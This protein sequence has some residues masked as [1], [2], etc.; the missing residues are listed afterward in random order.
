MPLK[1]PAPSTP[2]KKPRDTGV[3][4]FTSSLPKGTY[5]TRHS[6]PKT[7]AELAP[8]F[9]GTPDFQLKPAHETPK[10]LKTKHDKAVL[11]QRD[12]ANDKIFAARE[13]LATKSAINSRVAAQ[14]G[15]LPVTKTPFGGGTDKKNPYETDA[16]TKTDLAKSRAAQLKQGGL[17]DPAQHLREAMAMLHTSQ[18]RSLTFSDKHQLPERLT[19][20]AVSLTAE[21]GKQ[22]LAAAFGNHQT[23]L[24]T[25]KTA[26]Q[27]AA[28]THL[29]D[30]GVG[31]FQSQ[32]PEGTY[33]A[34]HF[35]A[36]GLAKTFLSNAEKGT[37]AMAGFGGKT[38]VD[39]SHSVGVLGLGDPQALNQF[40]TELS[41][42]TDKIRGAPKPSG[43]PLPH[44]D[45]TN[46][47]TPEAKAA[48]NGQPVHLDDLATKKALYGDFA[49]G[50]R[51]RQELVYLAGQNG[52]DVKEAPTW[53][54]ALLADYAFH[55]QEKSVT[56]F[57]RNAAADLGSQAA[58]A[59]AP[60]MFGNA[61][62]QDIKDHSIR[63][64]AR[65]AGG[66]A[67][68]IIDVT[69]G[70]SSH[71]LQNNLYNKPFTTA[72]VLLPAG[73]AAGLK[74]GKTLDALGVDS[75]KG[76][77]EV[78][79]PTRAAAVDRGLAEPGS[80]TITVGASQHPI[81]R[82]AQ[83]LHDRILAKGEHPDE[84][85]KRQQGR[86]AATHPAREAVRQA[87]SVPSKIGHKLEGK[88]ERDRLNQKHMEARRQEGHE[89]FLAHQKLLE[90]YRNLPW[91]KDLVKKG[92]GGKEHTIEDI[93]YHEG[94]G[95]SP[96]QMADMYREHARRTEEDAGRLDKLA[97]EARTNEKAAR[98]SGDDASASDFA[99]QAG[100]YDKEIDDIRGKGGIIEKQ[101]AAAKRSDE[102][103][104]VMGSDHPDVQ[105][106]VDAMRGASKLS[107]DILQKQGLIDQKG[108]LWGDWQY[109]ISAIDATEGPGTKLGG[110]RGTEAW[111]LVQ[112]ILPAREEFMAARADFHG[113]NPDEAAGLA[114][115]KDIHSSEANHQLNRWNGLRALRREPG[116]P[117]ENAQ[118]M[119][120]LDRA[121]ATARHAQ[122][123]GRGWHTKQAWYR[124]MT[125]E[126]NGLRKDEQ[127]RASAKKTSIIRRRE[128]DLAAAK[129]TRQSPQ[130]IAEMQ[131]LLDK[132]K[133]EAD[134][135][136]VP[137]QRLRTLERSLERA[138]V[139][140]NTRNLPDEV[141]DAIV[142]SELRR[143][144]TGQVQTFARQYVRNALHDNSGL[145]DL[146]AR[147]AD[148]AEKFKAASGGKTV[149]QAER[150]HL[151]G[152]HYQR[153]L[154]ALRE[155][156]SHIDPF[157]MHM[158]KPNT[159]Y[160]LQPVRVASGKQW[161]EA[162]YTHDMHFLVAR[163]LEGLSRKQ[164]EAKMFQSLADEPYFIS[165]PPS[166][167][168][169]PPGFIALDREL[170][171]NLQKIAKDPEQV[172]ALQK[173]LEEARGT[174]H[175]GTRV[176]GDD[177][178]MV[179]RHLAEWLQA[180]LKRDDPNRQINGLLKATNMYRRWML[181]SLPRTYVNN[182]LGNPIIAMVMGAKMRHYVE[183]RDLLKNH[184]E[185]LDNTLRK[186]GTAANIMDGGKKMT[187]WQ[188]M[189]RSANSFQED[190]GNMMVYLM[191]AEKSFR[192]G[193]DLKIWNSIDKQSSEYVQFLSDAAQGKNPDAAAWSKKSAEAFGDMYRTMK[194]DNTL[195][196]LFLFHRWVGHM[197]TLTAYT[198]PLKYPGR[199]L[200]LQQTA[201]LADQY[202]KEH[203]V[204]PDW[205]Q[206]MIPLWSTMEKAGGLPQSVTWALS[207]GGI[208]PF[209]TPGQTFDLGT[210]D[211][212]KFPGQSIVAA[213]LNPGLRVL[214]EFATGHRFDTLE[215]FKDWHGR[216]IS[217]FDAH[218]LA[219]G[220]IANTPVLNT[221]FPRSGLSDD[222]IQIP[223]PL[224]PQHPRW[225][226]AASNDPS[227]A[228]PQ[229]MGRGL[230]WDWALRIGAA[231]GAP[232]RPI[233]AAGERTNLSA[234][235]T[236]TWQQQQ[237]D[238]REAQDEKEKELANIALFKNDRA[239]WNK[240]FGIKP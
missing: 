232:I 222:T 58:L 82:V 150:M 158:H 45:I 177:T 35:D 13:A 195:A 201:Q 210:P 22:I 60:G 215:P 229:A 160:G 10:Q 225:S 76:S 206:G 115:N 167:S 131:R 71:S 43:K 101:L 88:I 197:I 122:E 227:Y 99:E 120:A 62:V 61:I 161:E 23:P 125:D 14:A 188:Q 183:A 41:S 72:S 56:G 236:V 1:Q 68:G 202:R 111:D 178:V 239:A 21:E 142:N 78:T 124:D 18:S 155:G 139:K 57:F 186:R 230:L 46:L 231:S 55:K 151:A 180:E 20:P 91:V 162:D 26:Q 3:G 108:R 138:D 4:F 240:K 97:E 219:Q 221:I 166:G 110:E 53:N 163:D 216:D 11:K 105:A 89:T 117:R 75:F 145:G 203:G 93:F 123:E 238:L 66:F 154:E 77:R 205:A 107:G 214:G 74:V 140:G 226:R 29:T 156:Q 51:A 17:L 218:V 16:T 196:S 207:G 8:D 38:G 34:S 50:A 65:I 164:V 113:V 12:A 157:H 190:I 211:Q 179:S 223:S 2:A 64:T 48:S 81:T 69:P 134:T 59:A 233:D 44:I 191:H 148:A 40:N 27:A 90:S 133:G 185:L 25:A 114:A 130:R 36:G 127:T 118:P 153:A 95:N 39:K 208:N 181:F 213:N 100:K 42:V 132:A 116:P 32:E 5:G 137:S 73:K 67:Q 143:K 80:Q 171:D 200:F 86:A 70:L 165:N 30:P 63:N 94:S 87:A 141:I 28:R 234:Q 199:F 147:I 84:R 119:P 176:E 235:K 7:K 126:A 136:F 159:D 128:S 170:W 224:T 19:R 33:G 47:L 174:S 83:A 106:A 52:H 228:S 198:M 103:G 92:W 98:L 15:L 189:W 192:T 96:S 79:L 187:G 172:A 129:A 135:P 209:A 194:H 193:H 168:T 109:R 49:L 152:G 31:F 85:T 121:A 24:V 182:A 6:K 9:F 217:G 146:E 104:H 220:I 102:S 184:P 175:A 149:E 144:A 112:K 173:H 37:A 54:D 212:P 204:F 237:A 169:V